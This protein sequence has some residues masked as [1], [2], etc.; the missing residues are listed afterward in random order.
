MKILNTKLFY[1]ALEVEPGDTLKV[2]WVDDD[3]NIA[4]MKATIMEKQTLDTAVLV[5]Y[6]PEEAKALGFKSVLGIFAGRSKS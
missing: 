2:T 3:K 4:H 5:E 1:V 6:S